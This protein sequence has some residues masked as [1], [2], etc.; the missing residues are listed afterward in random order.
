MV[1]GKSMTTENETKKKGGENL[2]IG[3]T[4]DTRKKKASNLVKKRRKIVV[5]VGP[6]GKV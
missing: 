1:Q 4:S 2:D 5:K 3:K 6:L